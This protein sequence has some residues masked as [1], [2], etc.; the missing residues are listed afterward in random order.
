[1]S[2]TIATNTSR[3]SNVIIALSLAYVSGSVF[4]YSEAQFLACMALFWRKVMDSIV[5]NQA[6]GDINE[7]NVIRGEG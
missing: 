7:T 3:N 5:L 1:M 2:A 4:A 6:G